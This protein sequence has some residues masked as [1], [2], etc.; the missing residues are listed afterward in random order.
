MMVRGHQ[1]GGFPPHPAGPQRRKPSQRA[2][3]SAWKTDP[4]LVFLLLG[5]FVIGPVA[6][7]V[8]ALISR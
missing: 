3:G 4:E 6:A 7:L 5:L 8:V 2:K 1:R